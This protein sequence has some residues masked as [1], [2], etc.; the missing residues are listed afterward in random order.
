MERR[1]ILKGIGVTGTTLTVGG[2]GLFSLTGSGAAANTTLQASD[3]SAVTTDGGDIEYVAFGGRLRFE[4]DGLDNDATY[5]RY[6][7]ETRVNT[8][9]GFSGW[10]SH[11]TDYGELGANWG[12]SNDATQQTGSDG[13]FQFKYG[14][15]YGQQSYAIAGSGSNTLDAQNK[16]N[17]SVFEEDT[18]GGE[19]VT[20]V[21]FRMTC[22][23]WDG[24][25]GNGGSK[26]IETADTAQFTVT[27]G[28]REA[29]ATTG[30][31]ISGVI[32]A[33]ES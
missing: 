9:G 28:N 26:L 4:W 2:I 32:G 10:R 16:Y 27:V 17:T 18:D 6:K 15:S 23:V 24:E 29:V 1:D 33:D 25:P 19:Q 11:G 31:E 8:G 7:I 13:L 30:G 12:G 21:Q 20:D 22:S 14:E 5:G 3:P